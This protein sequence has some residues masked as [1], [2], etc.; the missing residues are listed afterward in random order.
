MVP[1][2]V[3]KKQ[4]GCANVKPDSKLNMLPGPVNALVTELQSQGWVLGDKTP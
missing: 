4:L 1:E 3:V 2:Q